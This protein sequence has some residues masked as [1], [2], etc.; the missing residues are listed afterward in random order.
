MGHQGDM[1]QATQLVENMRAAGVQLDVGIYSLL[2]QGAIW[3]EDVQGAHLWAHEAVANGITLPKTARSML[4]PTHW[5]PRNAHDDSCSAGTS[6][7]KQSA[8]ETVGLANSQFN[9]DSA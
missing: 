2:V 7:P 3:A 6:T 4:K 5:V 9:A 8:R 1:Q